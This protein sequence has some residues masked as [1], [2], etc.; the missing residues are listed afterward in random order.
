MVVSSIA[1]NGIQL[2]E[3]FAFRKLA[4]SWCYKLGGLVTENVNLKH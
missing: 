4:Q 1:H 3:R 2:C